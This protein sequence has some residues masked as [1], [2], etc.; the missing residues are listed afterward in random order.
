MLNLDTHIVVAVL[1]GELSEKESSRIRLEP[2]AIS[3]IVLWELAKL[4]QLKR[5]KLDLQSPE[6]IAF[7]RRVTVIPITHEIALQSIQL[8]FKSDPADEIIA[9]TSIVHEIPL[10][11]RDR[12]LLKSRLTPISRS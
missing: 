7:L 8:D 2:L 1:S 10:V 3:G 4:V 11:T 9:A 12:R 6:F 5:L